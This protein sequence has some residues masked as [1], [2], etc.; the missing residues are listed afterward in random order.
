MVLWISICMWPAFDWW[1]VEH[2]Q[3]NRQ[4]S[5]ICLNSNKERGWGCLVTVCSTL[6]FNHQTPLNS[7]S[8]PFQNRL[9]SILRNISNKIWTRGKVRM[10]YQ[11][12]KA[13]Q[14]GR[15]GTNKYYSLYI[16]LPKVCLLLFIKI[17][18]RWVWK[19]II[20]IN[21]K[22]LRRS[23]LEMIHG[24]GLEKRNKIGCCSAWKAWKYLRTLNVS[25]TISYGLLVLCSEIWI[26]YTFLNFITIPVEQRKANST[27]VR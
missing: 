16:K 27:R 3:I 15:K 9:N 8:V 12:Q 25:S 14:Q 10:G 22:V 13:A 18:W 19:I 20:C 17:R 5:S 6:L 4:T 11:L 24:V 7:T 1:I 21:V 26:A 2:Y 23:I